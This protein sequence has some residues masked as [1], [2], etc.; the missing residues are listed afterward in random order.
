M[1]GKRARTE[2]WLFIWLGIVA[3]TVA[4]LVAAHLTGRLPLAIGGG[5]GIAAIAVGLCLLGLA[6]LVVQGLR[7]RGARRA[8]PARRERR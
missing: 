8:R 2:R 5:A 6:V 3:A 7:R 1:A 4:G